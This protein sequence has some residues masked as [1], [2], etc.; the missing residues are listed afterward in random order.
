M[1]RKIYNFLLPTIVGPDGK[2]SS[3]KITAFWFTALATVNTLCII[4]IVF[5]SIQQD[6]PSNLNNNLA[7]GYLIDLMYVLCGM[8]LLLFGIVTFQQVT[9]S[10]FYKT[11]HD[12]K[13]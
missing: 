8:I 4:A 10:K 12:K 9:T 3:R 13:D 6:K 2:T 11:P 7:L 1:I 5:F